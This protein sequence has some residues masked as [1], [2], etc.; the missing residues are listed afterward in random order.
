MLSNSLYQKISLSKIGPVFNLDIILE[1]IEAYNV[2]INNTKKDDILIFIG[3]S[4][5]YLSHI[6]KKYRKTFTVPFSGKVYSDEFSI[7][8]TKNINNYATILNNIGIT[9]KL[10]DSNNIIF[11]D[12]SHTGETPCLFAK[13]ILRCLGYIN[14]YSYKLSDYSDRKF[15]FINIVSNEQY[16]SWIKI[17]SKNYINLIGYLLMPNLVA[18]ANESPPKN[19]SYKIPR[20][21]PH[22]PYYK[23]NELPD[24]SSLIEGEKLIMKLILFHEFIIKFEKIK[25]LTQNNI[26][27]FHIKILFYFKKILKD[28]IDNKKH[29]LSINK[30]YDFIWSNTQLIDIID[31][32]LNETKFQIKPH[33]CF[34]KK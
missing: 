8:T 27:H 28:I 12:H 34:I 26:T 17:P 25:L 15:N 19:S 11:I 5:N 3:Q 22:Y 23:W 14:K 24:Y 31:T 32:I 18:F 2:L 6:V 16:P 13:I 20:S 33:I 1:I 4:P 7:P 10:L 30:D 29:N 9:R 21:I